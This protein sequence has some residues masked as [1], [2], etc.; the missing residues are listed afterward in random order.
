MFLAVQMLT[1]LFSLTFPDFIVFLTSLD[2][3]FNGDSKNVL[4]TVI[5]SLQMD[6]TDNF[7]PDCPFKLSFWQIKLDV[8]SD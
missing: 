6:L 3:K 8:L 5:F 2:R 1:Q 4:K 7:I